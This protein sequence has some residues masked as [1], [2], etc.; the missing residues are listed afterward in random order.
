MACVT[1]R[2]AFPSTTMTEPNLIVI[3]ASSLDTRETRLTAFPICPFKLHP[4][5]FMQLICLHVTR[6]TLQRP[7]DRRPRSSAQ[8]MRCCTTIDY[9]M[10]FSALARDTGGSQSAR[11]GSLLRGV[12][13]IL[14]AP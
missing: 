9:F 7:P 12:A 6:D 8:P 10:S 1:R 14:L 13:C 11:N 5:C 3:V 4:I 2:R